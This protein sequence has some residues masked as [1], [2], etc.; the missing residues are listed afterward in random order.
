MEVELISYTKNPDGVANM[1]AEICTF[2]DIPMIETCV[3][4]KRTLHHALDSGHESVI[5]HAC[6]T[7][8][9]SGVSR[10]LTHQLVRHRLASFSQ[11]SQRYV[12]MDRFDYVVPESIR[13]NSDALEDYTHLMETINAFYLDYI[14]PNDGYGIDLEDARYILPNACCTNIMITMN[15]RELRHFFAL[16]C[17]HRA[18]WEIRELAQKMLALVQDI[19][20]H[21]F[22]NAGASCDILGYCPEKRGCGKA[23]SL[24]QLKLAYE[25]D[26]END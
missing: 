8:A 18:Q 20:P 2:S 14:D 21:I 3:D 25:G 12:L 16:R 11:Q 5:E 13:S 17:C 24:D 9:V 26:Q 15:A 23:P 1:G 4:G 19:A 7:F 6:F 10:A 22:E